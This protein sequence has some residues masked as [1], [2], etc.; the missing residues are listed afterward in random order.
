MK[1][2]IINREIG[3]G[4]NVA[5]TTIPRHDRFAASAVHTPAV[6]FAL[7]NQGLPTLGERVNSEPSGDREVLIDEIK[8]RFIRNL[9]VLVNSIE[10]NAVAQDAGFENRFR[11]GT[12]KC[13]VVCSG[14]IDKVAVERPITN[15]AFFQVRLCAS[16][17]G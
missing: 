16:S 2:F 7:G 5:I 4:R 13:S 3:V 10:C 9:D 12:H 14:V 11:I 17:D 8:I 1:L 6:A 15:Q